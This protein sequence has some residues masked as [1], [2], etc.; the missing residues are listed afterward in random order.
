MASWE[1]PITTMVVTTMVVIS[2]KKP[3]RPVLPRGGPVTV[4]GAVPRCGG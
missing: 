2:E 3:G 1:K 4:S